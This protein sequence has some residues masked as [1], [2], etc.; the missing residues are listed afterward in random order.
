MLGGFE[1]PFWREFH[2]T[3][4]I[5]LYDKGPASNT[6]F[7]SLQLYTCPLKQLL[8]FDVEKAFDSSEWSCI[9]FL[10]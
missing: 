1:N 5:Q 7:S 10:L 9:F 2:S 8:Y 6:V 3:W 4:S